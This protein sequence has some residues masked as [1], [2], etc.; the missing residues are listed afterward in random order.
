MMH[1]SSWQRLRWY[2]LICPS[3]ELSSMTETSYF[4]QPRASASH[5]NVG[6]LLPNGTGS[7]SNRSCVG[8]STCCVVVIPHMLFPARSCRVLVVIQP[9]TRHLPLDVLTMMFCAGVVVSLA[10]A[11]KPAA[12]MKPISSLLGSPVICGKL[13]GVSLA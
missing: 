2:E 6:G 7:P 11:S 5:L 12:V 1:L 4:G 10:S 13:T 3:W 8:K 9:I